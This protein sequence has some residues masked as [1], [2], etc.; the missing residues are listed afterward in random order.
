MSLILEVGLLAAFSLG[1]TPYEKKDFQVP[2][3][4]VEK[5]VYES[6]YFKSVNSSRTMFQALDTANPQTMLWTIETGY[7]A[8]IDNG[9]LRISIGHTSEHEVAKTDKFTESYNYINV[10]Y[11]L[12][13][14]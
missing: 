12:E 13:Y 14:P 10:S 9:L 5:S 1:N 3:L 8:Q 4:L 6:F 11:R 2:Y 7:K